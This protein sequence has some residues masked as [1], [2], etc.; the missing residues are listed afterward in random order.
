MKA[1]LSDRRRRPPCRRRAAAAFLAV[2]LA[3]QAAPAPALAEAGRPVAESPSAGTLPQTGNDA[4]A[5]G[6]RRASGTTS[7]TPPPEQIEGTAV[8]AGTKVVNVD[9]GSRILP[10]AFPPEQG[11]S[12]DANGNLVGTPELDYWPGD[13]VSL[14]VSVRVKLANAYGEYDLWVPVTVQRRLEIVRDSITS[15]WEGDPVPALT[16][17]SPFFFNLK[18]IVNRDDA[19]I[20]STPVNGLS[21]APDGSLVGTPVV[22][23]WADGEYWRSISIPVTVT[24]GGQTKS[25]DVGASI[26][27]AFGATSSPA[28]G[29]VEGVPVAAGTRVVNKANP[30]YS[31]ITATPVSGLSVNDDGDLVGTPEIDDWADGETERVVEVQ[32]RVWAKLPGM[33]EKQAIVKVPVKVDRAMAVNVSVPGPQREKAEVAPGIVVATP[34]KA[35]AA[36]DSTETNGLFVGPDGALAGTPAITDWGPS[37]E[38]RDVS[39]PVFVTLGKEAKSATV[40]VPVQRDTDG[41]GVPDVDDPDDDGD[42][43]PDDLEAVYGTDPKDPDS[44]PADVALSSPNQTVREGDSVKDMI[45][46]K[47]PQDKV[48]VDGPAGLT[49][50]EGRSVVGGTPEVDDWADGETE[51]VVAGVLKVTRPDGSVVEKDFSVKVLRSVESKKVLPVSSGRPGAPGSRPGTTS[52]LGLLP[53]MG[54]AAIPA[55]FVTGGLATVSTV[56]LWV[57]RKRR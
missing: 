50:D 38:Q 31:K 7:V 22:D 5:A 47:N 19:V 26:L 18:I 12:V 1:K 14:V 37:E 42:G 30:M 52:G 4:L 10:G 23:D 11:L 17:G 15:W 34:T 35:G 43:V 29:Q 55:A 2:L 8:P 51:R 56:L 32:A 46:T 39:V 6:P 25:V 45:V 57:G 33:L 48:V 20:T 54:D 36:I 16:P 13:K 28:P 21:I 41:D 40:T 49:Y 24:A 44:R 27:K 53:A 9:P 3:L